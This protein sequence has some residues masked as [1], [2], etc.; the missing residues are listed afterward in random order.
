MRSAA[1]ATFT[2]LRV[3]P[4]ENFGE[5]PDDATGGQIEALWEFALLFKFVDRRI[6]ERHELAELGPP[7]GSAPEDIGRRDP[8]GIG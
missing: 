2:P 8:F 3:D 7:D 5:G 1:F 6:R 4:L